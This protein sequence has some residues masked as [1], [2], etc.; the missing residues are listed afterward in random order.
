MLSPRLDAIAGTLADPVTGLGALGNEL[1]VELIVRTDHAVVVAD[2][3]GIIRFWNPAAETMFGYRAEEALGQTL[4]VIIPENLRERHWDGYRRVMAT[5]ETVYSGRMLAVPALRKDG[6]R[7]SVEFS[8]TL[9]C[10]DAGNVAAIAAILRDVTVR[11]NEERDL[12]RRL[13]ELERELA[14]LRS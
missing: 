8:V 11:W 7:I 13:A 2:P 14:A 9:L 4:D 6:A 1:Q 5:G 12:R 10:D 3:T